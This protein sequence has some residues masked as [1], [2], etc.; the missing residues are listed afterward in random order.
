[1]NRYRIERLRISIRRL[2]VIV[3]DKIGFLR[4]KRRSL[5]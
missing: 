3:K 2:W 1:M 4:E 5:Y